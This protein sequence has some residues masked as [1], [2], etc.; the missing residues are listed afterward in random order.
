MERLERA[1]QGYRPDMRSGSDTLIRRPSNHTACFYENDAQLVARISQFAAIGI[2]ADETVIVIATGSHADAIEASLNQ[3]GIDLDAVRASGRYI[4]L[5]AAETLAQISDER[6]VD[7]ARFHDIVGGL[8][9]LAGRFGRVRAF[10]EMVALLWESGQVSTAIDLEALWNDL[11]H[12]HH[13]NLCCA[14]P[15]ASI[16]DHNDLVAVADVCGQH[17]HIDP[18]AGYEHTDPTA[19]AT[20]P[21]ASRMFLPVPTA[22]G[23]A[24]RFV[25]LTLD[26]WD[27]GR[28]TRD[29]ALLVCSELA[30][31]AMLHAESPFRVTLELQPEQVRIALRDASNELPVGRVAHRDLDGGRGIALV[32]VLTQAWG[33]D[34][35]PDGKVVWAELALN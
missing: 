16:T 11:A 8:V 10:G 31:N 33:V 15:L 23:A 29:D 25:G 20:A 35:L 27:V 6:H 13:F 3:G 9:E 14:Y 4:E 7:S 34:P 1:T 28:D 12:E 30:T 18:P 26:G 21:S 2:A 19:G 32:E 5:D 22:I 17:S 24:R